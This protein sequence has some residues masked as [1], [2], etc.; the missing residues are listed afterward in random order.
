MK[1]EPRIVQAKTICITN[2]TKAGKRKSNKNLSRDIQII[3][4]LYL[5]I[6]HRE[7]KIKVKINTFQFL[8]MFWP[9]PFPPKR[10]QPRSKLVTIIE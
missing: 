5:S 3:F 10:P 9:R 4:V 6:L 1:D 2:K 7:I 8:P